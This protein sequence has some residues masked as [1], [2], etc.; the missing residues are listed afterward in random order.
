MLD[1]VAGLLERGRKSPS[2]DAPTTE[3][4]SLGSTLLTPRR[5]GALK[6]V[7]LKPP[8]WITASRGLTIC[9]QKHKTMNFGAWD[10]RTLMDSATSDRP[11]RRTAIIARELRRYR[12]DLATLS[13]TQL[14]D[15]GKRRSVDEPRIH[16]PS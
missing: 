8:D 13:E 4:P 7:C 1:S 5:E 15:E 10:V 3:Q 9:G 16:G 11:E 14:A 2:P 12:I 6:I